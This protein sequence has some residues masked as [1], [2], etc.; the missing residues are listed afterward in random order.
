MG[1]GDKTRQDILQKVVVLFNEKGY[2][3][4]SMQDI[5]TVT[6]VQRGGIYN[7]FASKEELALASFEYACSVLAKCLIRGVRPQK[8]AVGR[9]NAIASS[10]A[11]LYTQNPLFPFGCQVMN[12]TVEAKRQMLPLRQKAQEAMNQLKQLIT[13]TTLRGIEQSELLG[14][15]NPNAVAAV[16]ISTLEGAMLLSVLY[17]DPTYLDHAVNHLHWYVETLSVNPNPTLKVLDVET[18]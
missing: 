17:D 6:G 8:T 12:T 5:T 11:E 9:L 3:A 13:D 4:T 10:F 16:F 2:A 14:S 1:K 18:V 7:H 15:I